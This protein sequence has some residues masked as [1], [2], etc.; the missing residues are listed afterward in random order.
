MK[1]PLPAPRWFEPIE[2]LTSLRSGAPTTHTGECARPNRLVTIGSSMGGYAAVRAALA[3]NADAALAFAPQVAIDP[4]TRAERGLP[5]APFDGLLNGL[6]AFGEV[7]GVGDV[8]EVVH[9][10]RGGG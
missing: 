9:L 1:V 3:L 2:E 4:S 10:R 5:S 8:S 7:E 6:K